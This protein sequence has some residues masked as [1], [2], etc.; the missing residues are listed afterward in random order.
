MI[1]GVTL[2]TITERPLNCQLSFSQIPFN[3]INFSI[4][5]KV[6]LDIDTISLSLSETEEGKLNPLSD[7]FSLDSSSADIFT[8][9]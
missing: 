6:L 7:I 5:S 3:A 4:S 2:A 9:A 8:L 1:F